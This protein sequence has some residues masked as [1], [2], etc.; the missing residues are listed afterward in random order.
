MNPN[1][2][3][4]FIFTH[5]RAGNVKTIRTMRKSG[6]TAKI[7]LVIDNEDEQEQQYRE[8]YDGKDGCSIYVFDKTVAYN[9]TDTMDLNPSKGSVVYARNM[10]YSIAEELGYKYFVMLEDDYLDYQH[11]WVKTH[12]DDS[13]TL[14]ARTSMSLDPSYGLM[15]K[16]IG[17]LMDY[18]KDSQATQIGLAQAG[19]LVGGADTFQ[20]FYKNRVRKIMNFFCCRTDR[21]VK[22]LGRMNDDV[23]SYIWRG[24]QGVIFLSFRELTVKQELTQMAMGGMSADYKN[25]GTYTKSF[26]SVMLCPSFVTI[27][28]MGW[29]NY[30][31]HHQIEWNNAVPK[32][33]SD[34]YKKSDNKV[35]RME[36]HL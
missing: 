27:G 2:Y 6:C 14:C 26:Y 11:R 19:D 21:P 16:C 18:L 22:W 3:C 29:H 33:L 5:G 8:L 24:S 9:L 31:M 23:N 25:F 13:M 10:A 15:D 4:I 20:K 28:T 7:I 1:E 34:S 36:P 32:I 30:R 12:P 17:A 35:K